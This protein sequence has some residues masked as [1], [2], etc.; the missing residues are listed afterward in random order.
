MPP[1]TRVES[2]NT[3]PPRSS[4]TNS[5]VAIVGIERGG[6]HG[7]GAGGGGHLVDRRLRRRSG[8]TRARPWRRW[9]SPRRRG[10]RRRAPGARAGPPARPS[11]TTSPS[12]GSRSRMRWVIAVGPRRP[13][14][15]R[16]VLDRPLVGEPQQRAAVVAERVGHVALGGLRPEPHGLHP[17]GRVLRDVLLHERLL[18][19]VHPDHRQRPVLELGEDPVAHAVEVVDQV[20]LGGLGPVEERAGRGW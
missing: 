17:V 11:G 18:A 10:R 7:D 3:L 20:A 9:S 16:V 5:V 4:F 15:R 8:R 14:Q 13:H 1:P 2:T 12:G 6:A 19:P